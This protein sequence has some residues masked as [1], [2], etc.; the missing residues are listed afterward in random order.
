MSFPR[1]L[2]ALGFV[3]TLVAVSIARGQDG[4]ALVRHAPTIDGRIDGSVQQFA[5]ES[6]TLNGSGVVT[7]DWL[8]PGTP[9]V[10]LNG[11]PSFS[12]VV[13]AAGS[14][15][16]SNYQIT[17][18][19][20]AALGNL[21][22]RTDP[23]PLPTVTAPSV[24]G[25]TRYVT[26]NSA[27]QGVG[28]W[29]TVRNLTLNGNVGSVAVPGGVYG[30]FVA[31]GNSGLTLGVPGS[32]VPTIYAFQ[33]LTLNGQ[34]VLTVVGPVVV[35]VA[36]GFS[37]NGSIGASG[38]PDWLVMRIAAGGLTLN[39]G[40]SLFGYVIA[41]N[42]PVIVNGNSRLVGDVLCDR[43]TV[44][45]NGLLRLTN[46]PPTLNFTSPPTGTI[47]LA[48]G[49]F[50]LA[51]D[52]SDTDGVIQRVEFYSGSVKI[53]EADQPPYLYTWSA[54]PWGTYSLTAHA[55]DNTGAT[56]VSP[57]VSVRVNAPPT[58]ALT[59][60]VDHAVVAAPA[61]VALGVDASD[62]DGSVAKVEFY[63]GTTKLGESTAAPFT[64]TWSGVQS[65]TYTITA[66]ATDDLGATTTSAPISFTADAPP[67]V[68][69]S[70]PAAGAIVSPGAPLALS[71][72]A[73]DGDGTVAKVDFYLGDTLLGSVTSPQGA[74]YSLSIPAPASG[75][76]RFKAVATDN[77]GIATT[78]SSAALVVDAPPTVSLTAPPGGAV[79]IA[80]APLT[81][82]ATASDSDGMVARVDFYLDG[83]LAASCATPQGSVFNV[84]IAAPAAG[85]HV[86]KAV[87]FDNLGLSTATPA[88]SVIVDVPP[89][90]A[91]SSPSDGAVIAAPATVNL[92][93]T[94]ADS[95][96]SVAKVEFFQGATKLGEATTAPYQYAVSGLASGSYTFTARAT[97]N[98]G[99]V[100]SSEPIAVTVDAPPTVA[101]TSPAAGASV[102]PNTSIAL[103]ASA[104]DSDGTVT[105]VEFFSDST[106]LAT[107][108]APSAGSTFSA[109]LA[110]GLSA[111]TYTLTARATDDKGIS[112]LSAP[113]ALEVKVVDTLTVDAGKD[114][115]VR[116]I[117]PSANAPK[118]RIVI[119][120]DEWALTD[121]GYSASASAGAFVRNLADFLSG[122][123]P[124]AKF[125]ADTN[126]LPGSVDFIYTGS[127]LAA[128]MASGGY[129]WT[130]SSTTPITLETLRQYDAVFLGANTVDNQVLIDYVNG[131]G[132][133]YI[134]AGTHW[135]GG[136]AESEAALWNVFLN[137][138]G[139]NYDSP[140][141]GIGGTLPVSSDYPLFHGISTLYFANGNSVTRLNDED[142]YTIVPFVY[143]GQGLIGVAG[144]ITNQAIVQGTVSMN[145]Q[146]VPPNTLAYQWTQVSGPAQATIDAPQSLTS[147]VHFPSAG[148]Y[149]FRLSASG[150]GNQGQDEVSFLVDAAPRVD[151]GKDQIVRDNSQPV[152]LSATISDDG[153]PNGASTCEWST[154]GGPGTVTFSDPSS[155]STQATFSSAGIYTLKVTANDGIYDSS[156][157]VEIRVGLQSLEPASGLAAWWPLNASPKDIGGGGHDL[158]VSA[159]NY[160]AGEVGEALSLGGTDSMAY[161]KADPDLDIGA[162]S[163]G[164]T[165][166]YWVN[167][168]S[169]LPMLSWVNGLSL[170]LVDGNRL[171]MNLR[172]A[173][174]TDHV[175]DSFSWGSDV[176]WIAKGTW[177]HVALAYD[178][179]A[180]V[181][182]FYE[183]GRL[184][185]SLALGSVELSTSGAFRLGGNGFV[186]LLD[187]VTLYRRALSNSEIA[188]IF[189]AGAGGKCPPGGNTPPAVNA[190]PD[191][192]LINNGAVASLNGVVSDDNLPYGPPTVSWSKVTGPGDVVFAQPDKAATTATF[193]EPGVYLLSLTGSDGYTIPVTD[194][195]E[196]RVGGGYLEP[197]SSLAAWWPGN[198]EPHEIVHGGHDVELI[199]GA[200]Y[201]PAVVSE[202]FSFS[203]TGGYGQVA[204]HPDIDVGSSPQGYT[205]EFWLS[206]K[207]SAPFL[208]W[209]GGAYFYLKD[210]NRLAGDLCDADGTSH[211]FDTF[212]LGGGAVM[213]TYTQTWSHIA[214]TCDRASGT[215]RMYQ[216]GRLMQTVNLGNHALATAGDLVLGSPSF[217]G[218]ID[219]L[220]LYRRPLA[221]D[222]I[223][224]IYQAGAL[225]K[226]PPD[227]N[228]PPTVSAGPAITVTSTAVSATLLG[229]VSD[230]QRPYGP[231]LIA[232]SLLKGPGTVSFADPSQPQTTASFS[233]PG[234]YVLRLTAD[235]Q[236]SPPVSD[237][238]EA[239]VGGGFA[240]LP[241]G[242]C[243]W[244]PGNG[245]HKEIIHG[246]NLIRTNNG[247]FGDGEVGQAFN[248]TG[249]DD[250]AYAPSNPDL[251]IGSSPDG[252]SIEFWINSTS[253]AP[254]LSWDGGA[255]FYLFDGNR[256][257]G[258]LREANGTDHAFDTFT[259]KGGDV[260]WTYTAPWH[261]IVVTYERSTGATKMYLD[262]L[263]KQ[264]VTFGPYALGTSGD[265]RLGGGA[266]KG[267]LDE[268]TLYRRPI[269]AAEVAA[270]YA[271]GALGKIP[272]S[273]QAPSVNAG[274]DQSIAIDADASLV[275][276]AQDDGLPNPPSALSFL[277]SKVS[278]PGNVV[279]SSPTGLSTTANFD[280]IGVYHL[281]LTASDSA[282]SASGD[283]TVT[284]T[285]S[286]N[287]PPV[288]TVGS[289]PPVSVNTPVTFSVTATD[290]GLPNPPGVLTYTWSKVS[291]PGNVVFATPSAS[292]TSATFDASGSYVVRIAVSDSALNTVSDIP[293]TV[294]TLPQNPPTVSLYEPADGAKLPASTTFEIAAH[295]ASQG[296]P[297]ASV[298]FYQG[299][300]KLGT[301]TAPAA[302]DP[303][304][305]FWPMTGGLPVGIYTFTAVATDSAG[306]STTSAPVSITVADGSGL[307]TT[308]HISSPAE[309]G[310]ISAPTP[311]TGVVS[312]AFL[313]SWQLQYRL[314]AAEGAT[315]DAWTTLATGTAQVGTP[316]T[317][318]TPESPGALGTFDPTLLING[319]YELQLAVTDT[320]GQTTTTG[321]ITLVVE[322][323]MK[324]GA[325]T[326]A[327][328]DMKIPT[329]GIPISITRTYDSRDSRPGD[330]GPG[331]HVALANIRVQK[332]RNLGTGWWQTPQT[333]TG[334]QFYTVDP[335][336]D[337]IV[338]IVMPDGTTDRFKAGAYVKNRVGDPDNSSFAAV[339]TSGKI[340]FYP[341]GNTYDTLEPLDASG[342]LADTFWIGGTGT[343]D[344]T[345]DD[346]G[347]EVWNPTRFRLTTKDGTVYL[348]DERLGLLEMHDLNG[349]SLVLNRDS[350]NN[351]TSIVSNQAA[352]GGTVSTTVTLH[353]DASN[354]ID[355]IRDPAGNDL[356]Y[357]YDSS[358]RLS[359]FTDRASNQTQFF[360]ENAAFPYYLTKIVDPRGTPAIRSEYDASGRLVKQYDANGKEIDFNTG[361]DSLGRFEKVADRLGNMTTYYYDDRGNVVEKID[362]LN[363]AT[364]YSY[365]SDSELVKYETDAYGNVKSFA[366]DARGDVTVET[367]GAST[368]EDPA[369]PTT[370]YTTRTDYNDLAAPTLIT[371][372]DGRVQTFSYFSGTTNLQS[373]TIA[374]GT[375]E[376]ATT[377]YTYN[378]DGTIA[379]MTDA[380]GNATGYTYEYG[381]SDAAYPGAVKRVTVKVVDPAGA[382]GS[383]P[384]NS[385]DLV[386][387]TTQSYY[388]AQENLVA[389][390]VTR[391]LA[392]GTSQVVVTRYAYDKENRRVATVLPDG[393]VLETRY[394]SFGKVDKTL[395]WQSAADYASA[396]DALARVASYAYDANGNQTSVTHPD[397][398]TAFAHFD[399]ENRRDWSQ[400]ARGYRT[401]YVRDAVGRLRFT[402]YPDAND[403][404]FASA[405]SS[406]SDPKL[407]DNPRT[408]TVYDLIGRVTDTYDERRS[409]TEYVYFPDGT[410]DV[411]RRKTLIQHQ[412]APL[413]NLETSYQ[414]D[415]AGNVRF[416]TD[417]KGA[418]VET[419]Y[420]HQGR[421]TQVNYPATDEFPATSTTTTYDAL[422]HR[423]AVTDQEGKTTHYRYDGLGR[424]VEVRQYLD[425]SLAASDAAF[426]LSPSTANIVSTQY[427]YDALGNETSQTDALGRVTSYETDTMGRRTKR[428]L[429][430]DTSESV[431]LS[432]LFQYD[433]WG[434]LSKRTDFSGM[435]TTF[436]YDAMGR[437][438]S[439][440]ADPTHPSFA[441]ANA[442]ARVEYD[443]DADGERIAARTYNKAGTELYSESTPR[444]ARGRVEYKDA[445]GVRLD[446][447]YFANGLLQDVVASDT[448]GENVGYRYDELNRLAH[449]D[450]ASGPAG[451]LRT[452][453]YTYDANGNLGSVTLANGI[454]QTYG[455]DTLNRLRTLTVAQLTAMGGP[456]AGTVDDAYT[457]DLTASGRRHQVLE[458]AATTTYAYDALY[459]L[460]GEAVTGG[461]ASHPDRNL[462]YTLDKVG[463]RLSRTSDLAAVPTR[464]NQTYNARD[465]LS[466]DTYDNN[467][468]TTAGIILDS[469]SSLPASSTSGTDV[470][471]FQDRLIERQ[472]ADGTSV[473]IAYDADGNRIGKTLFDTTGTVVRSTSYLVDTNN[474]TG[475]AQVL[476]ESST[477][478]SA[479][480][481]KVYTYGA[482]LLSY[483]L[484]D[485]RSSIPA[486]RFFL[487]DGGG[488]VRALADETGAITDRYDYD[489]FGDLTAKSGTTD[490]A[491]LYRGEQYDADLG[492]YYLRVRYL[493]ADSG[494]FWSM[495]TYDGVRADPIS[496]HKYLYGQADPLMFRDASGRDATLAELGAATA[497]IGTLAVLAV[498]QVYQSGVRAASA[499]IQAG[500]YGEE[501]LVDGIKTNLLS[502]AMTLELKKAKE[503][504]EE[505][506]K[507]QGSAVIGE[508]MFRVS[509]A[510]EKLGA[511]T[512]APVSFLGGL[513]PET[514]GSQSDFDYWMWAD[515]AWIRSVMAR[516]MWIYDI[517]RD[518]TR[519]LQG[520]R[521]SEFYAMELEETAMYPLKSG[522]SFPGSGE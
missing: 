458:G 46:L 37:C 78:V 300:N 252:F 382:A 265:F 521:Q 465:W 168:G 481:T 397:G 211:P 240:A 28:D 227:D 63:S 484:S 224:A 262:G 407:A 120:N 166:E 448:G 434:Q 283:V 264:S 112:S 4:R 445:Q 114:Q 183:D 149:T 366:Y 13:D 76:Y 237:I 377:N 417:P 400:D 38:R 461:D 353:R 241:S 438:T 403:G 275:G 174:G 154:I 271:A 137:H 200:S 225:G 317:T 513:L 202:G 123:K 54:V 482:S 456:A 420:D 337:R 518:E 441:L 146:P 75:T 43:L 454:E 312:D 203:G 319:I 509:R 65:G 449:V 339:V 62:P 249:T 113:V 447:S 358:G 81:V 305:Y 479:T 59:S 205:I 326:L 470:Y 5:G 443:Y 291:G 244:W 14:A 323:N 493:N 74:D 388:D 260:M 67:V 216:N 277:W 503:T 182:R 41:P 218:L 16:P 259:L 143:Q 57:A 371:D 194:T 190:G 175:Y 266:F 359:I 363:A 467:G 49:A 442:I 431:A 39:G 51:A 349:N 6:A 295:V 242:A 127:R 22:R 36:N 192:Y 134:S 145:G 42:G 177:H 15:T 357:G 406:A 185:H 126:V 2:C 429:P 82:S 91:L 184:R 206:S 268:V 455:Y 310:R 219:E 119:N 334:I 223:A 296:G 380:L 128:T 396:N 457:Y 222:D 303:T 253:T 221:A 213:W 165:I 173:D 247:G 104:S 378:A 153:L 98:L 178:R 322:G 255:Y 31:N 285:A 150:G 107:A 50:A 316:A 110:S 26:L 132:S 263:L 507:K 1:T 236:L 430:K 93:A 267:L 56:T 287:L 486:S 239:R 365:Y 243:A 471:D 186:G 147:R 343:Q 350:Q 469:R 480:T 85:S 444:D 167:S 105:K 281:R 460:T 121:Q 418:K 8:M 488:S 367:I 169:T 379:S 130:T 18:N 210:G 20:S 386:L 390:V 7:G 474:L 409:H 299:T 197:D 398:T 79:L 375:P 489:A 21:I 512:F 332:N 511:E 48:P 515:R 318:S 180:G 500:A 286:A 276:T 58:I 335:Q 508:N 125:L 352:P 254:F 94:A 402:I 404:T 451:A 415:K 425:Q 325:F 383:D 336:L 115:Q 436:A 437:L 294:T 338:T 144:N 19:G 209:S 88:V 25:G 354:R 329:P 141:N 162:S 212:T 86:L 176:M 497:I 387:R 272:A 232:W 369:S 24:P 87:A 385:A 69:W 171:G 476:E 103:T 72:S 426:S 290:D 172:E 189:N 439:K 472:K 84:S 170:Y 368:S 29:G 408:E 361:V 499:L 108:A 399:A 360:Y 233:A 435:T 288:V 33:H 256:L 320:T 157:T 477:A 251:D 52:A 341:I 148:L 475:Y 30:D 328:E 453:D 279:F 498:P 308:A 313:Q 306:A 315:P 389:E 258:N 405:P 195:M 278:G 433:G 348:L 101:L 495:D 487:T 64:F 298:A 198:G 483:T 207:S 514:M 381:V 47:V 450:D 235:D 330:F 55:V 374:Y 68:V 73:T 463:N 351:V 151:A 517:G 129:S 309:D 446:Y 117:A 111:G 494:R 228:T 250:F 280:Q 346:L 510:A 53:G 422:G 11:K 364:T 391:T 17:L 416:V 356:T 516:R 230:D 215:I 373:N 10:R 135:S 331:W 355:Y 231:P 490:N 133:V 131:G 292:S 66:V 193:S 35:T 245:D 340:K 100:A 419:V 347:A 297:I 116:Y 504:T 201:G 96:G 40:S 152:A 491:Y 179:S 370:G 3:C 159:E 485:S 34:G 155:A 410:P 80:G 452:T 304:T 274:A 423:I 61:S 342:N 164:F 90:I 160:V 520:R 188:A 136:D 496:L 199:N 321:P 478:S 427:A 139:L 440:S 392:D 506:S 293:V 395:E 217:S 45:G 158:S 238:V 248:F 208:S 204:A 118:G 462:S 140:Y 187:E 345:S 92:V 394:T 413:P 156:K 124:G 83:T 522:Y 466:T 71:V 44:N 77:L 502:L 261:H 257:A 234:L 428:S 344:I 89:T 473:T 464:T 246:Y 95:D 412:T 411:H 324:L 97:D 226:C 23:L 109:T 519:F 70:S 384:G 302:G 459:R 376:A 269:T 196:V 282:L 191:Q 421:P 289:V 181:V 99:V 27:G 327:F 307:T 270:I 372:P 102:A 424:L 501:K 432:E 393:R 311:L 362:P 142:P 122:G 60:P 492:L 12:G 468:N 9:V 401:F 414:Y 106:L 505:E 284:V 32:T 273:N 229:Q 333:G 314:K 138:F 163:S 220:T 161:A 214:V 301:Q